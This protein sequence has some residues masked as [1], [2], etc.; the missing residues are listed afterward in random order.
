MNQGRAS[1]PADALVYP[2]LL[3]FGV[4]DAAGY[5]VLAPVLPTIAAATRS[6]P[7]AIGLLVASFPLAMLAGFALAGVATRRTHRWVQK[8]GRHAATW[9]YS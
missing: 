8:L 7:A 1:A 9:W 3:A 6:G 2:A 5:S 4:L